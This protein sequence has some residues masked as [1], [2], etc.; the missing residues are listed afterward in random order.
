MSYR[1][2][3]DELSRKTQWLNV[4]SSIVVEGCVTRYPR[5]KP[6]RAVRNKLR[7]LRR[8]KWQRSATEFFPITHLVSPDNSSG[9]S[10]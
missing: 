1:E 7:T 10:R 8:L 3:P 6:R 4:A 2:I 5:V 9:I